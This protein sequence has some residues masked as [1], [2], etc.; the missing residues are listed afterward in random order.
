VRWRCRSNDHSFR[1]S[2]CA[3]CV[4]RSRWR[5]IGGILERRCANEGSHQTPRSHIRAGNTRHRG[6]PSRPSPSVLYLT[7]S[8]Y[9]IP[10]CRACPAGSCHAAGCPSTDLS[11]FKPQSPRSPSTCGSATCAA[12]ISSIDYATLSKMKNGLEVSPHTRSRPK[13]LCMRARSG[14]RQGVQK[15]V[16]GGADAAGVNP[17]RPAVL[18][19]TAMSERRW[20]PC[21]TN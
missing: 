19:P 1:V 16:G 7:C 3:T 18:C 20:E 14:V 12:A 4:R 21:Q 17:C 15:G 6:R 13:R 9:H 10:P 5:A 11:C 8:V 2:V